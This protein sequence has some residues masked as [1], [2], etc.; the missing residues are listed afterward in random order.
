MRC[1]KGASERRA[2]VIGSDDIKCTIANQDQMR[3]MSL[4]SLSACPVRMSAGSGK[5]MF[6]VLVLVL[7]LVLHAENV[8]LSQMAA[9]M[10]L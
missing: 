3:V 1:E 10:C 4:F 2:R 9:T 5:W 8:S 7:V 6:W